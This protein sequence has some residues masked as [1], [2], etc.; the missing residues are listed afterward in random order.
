MQQTGPVQSSHGLDKHGIRNVSTAHWN[1]TTASLYEEAIRRGEGHLG[2]GGAFI[3]HT[4]VHTG[5]SPN[6]KFFTKEP[7]SE[8]NINWGN[9]NRPMEPAQFEGLHARMLAYFEG[10]ELFV[11]DCYAGA[12]PTFQLHVRV[13]TETAWH[14][15]FARNMFIQPTE[16]ALRNFT[17]Q[18]TILHAP[19]FQAV[20]EIDGTNSEVFVV[21]D[22]SKRLILIGGSSYAGEIKK[23][24]FSILN[25]LLPE[26]GV[27]P[28]HC[29]A[30]IGPEGDSAIFFGLSGTGKTTLSADASRTLIGDDE[31]GWGDNGVFNFEGG[32]YA[33]VIRLSQ[34]A[35]PEI[36]ATTQRFGTI[37]ENVVFDE[38]S[39]ILNLDDATLTENTRASYP[40]DF[41]PNASQTG[42]GKHPTTIIM[43]TADAFGVL[44]PISRL[45]PEQ[46]MYHFLS[47]YTARV[48]GTEKGVGAEPQATFSACFGAPFM[49]RQPTVYAE[50]LRKKIAK[51]KVDC[52]LVNTGWSGGVYGVGKRMAIGHTRAMVHAALDGRLAKAPMT[53]DPNFGMA[54]PESCP[55]VPDGVLNSRDT[56]ADKQAYD[57]TAR[58]LTQRFE[59][60]FK[61]FEKHVDDKVK[62]AS[63][64]AA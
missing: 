9:V 35:E 6:D 33:K 29:S 42:T 14:N 8:A 16:D 36:F 30:N 64:R 11:Q 45:S 21:V 31:H 63:I 53:T 26:R 18:F 19:S 24:V 28:M 10:R 48:A 47:G 34:E 62:A 46:A 54:V 58:D 44:P 20:P 3:A 32:C 49:P 15:L 4:G 37:L 50:L 59:E 12:D 38:G 1:Y 39:R 2:H 17:P 23:S 51:H 22:F 7:G 40:I 41:I 56:W 13:V 25:Y 52:W 60:N 5:R 55:D 61:Q 43:L 57:T 27:L